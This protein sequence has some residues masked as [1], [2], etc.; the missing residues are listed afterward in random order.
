MHLQS[1][2]AWAAV[3][4]LQGILIVLWAMACGILALRAEREGLGF[5]KTF[6]I[7]FF[8]TPIAG[9]VTISMSRSAQPDRAVAKS[10]IRNS[11]AASARLSS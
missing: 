8:M 2:L 5:W 4:T 1:N 10:P 3:F 9:F 7:S 6:L 11:V